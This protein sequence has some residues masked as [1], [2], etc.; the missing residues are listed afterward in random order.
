MSS[1][2]VVGVDGGTTKTIA[3]VAD[4]CGRI[5]GAGRA[6]NSNWS[7][8]DVEEPM[9]VVVAAVQEA[10][11]QAGLSGD[12]VA[13][14]VFCL[15]GADWPEDH[16]RRQ[17]VLTRSRL[18]RRVIVKNDALAGWRAGTRQPYGVVV[19]AGTGTN[20]CVVTPDGREW[21]YGYYAWYGG[22]ATLSQEA[23][24]AVLRQ[25]DG[26]GAPTTLTPLVLNWLGYPTVDDLLK[27]VVADQLDHERVLTL[28]PLVFE[29]AY[30]GDEVAA[31]LI[32]KQGLV[33][34]GY[35]TAAIRRF[36]MGDIEFDVV[37]SGSLFKGQGSLL[38][39]TVTQAIHR[40]APRAR[41]A[42]VQ[43]EPAVGAVLLAYDAL[44]LVVGEE[45]YDNLAQTAP[46]PEFFS[47][48]AGEPSR[49]DPA[50]HSERS[51]E[52]SG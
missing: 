37:L 17:A 50:C 8:P 13:A 21:C 44:G 6:G 20:T 16:E 52:S 31:D 32:V 43:F 28:C 9:R 5:L 36:E 27:A 26:R 1:Q 38:V 10:L 45:M 35:A 14:G 33:L 11:G 34:A 23:I 51:E 18:A 49:S 48:H 2:Y 7:G 22:A 46:A 15:A 12:H 40:L 47:T 42:R 30:G 24:E 41:I 25:E 39:D 29:A 4:E 3:L 19:A